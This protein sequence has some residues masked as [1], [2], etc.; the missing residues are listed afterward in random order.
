M[1]FLVHAAVSPQR[2]VASRSQ[3]F[4]QS[5]AGESHYSYRVVLE[6]FLPVLESLGE[7]VFIQNPETE[8][9]P[10]YDERSSRGEECVFLSFAPPQLTPLGLRCR[11]IPVFA[12]E[13]G[14]IPQEP[15]GDNPRNDWRHVFEQVGSAITHSTFARDAV[16]RVMGEAY[17]IISCPSP[18]WDRY[19][20][21]PSAV[22]VN[23][24]TGTA[25]GSAP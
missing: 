15:F 20:A 22:P 11:T 7:V 10:L 2:N 19:G 8:V 13:F 5:S 9:D 4:L 12:W 17:P 24:I 1:I 21:E 23:E 14:D 6:Q 3:E 16:H 25:E 18:V